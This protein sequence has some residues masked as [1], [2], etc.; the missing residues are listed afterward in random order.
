MFL[1]KKCSAGGHH[2]PYC[3]DDTAEEEGDEDVFLEEEF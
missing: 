2:A 1:E 3:V